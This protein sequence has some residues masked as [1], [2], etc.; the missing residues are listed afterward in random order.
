MYGRG[1]RMSVCA[2]VRAL[3]V[4]I[5]GRGIYLANPT[6]YCDSKFHHWN[7]SPQL[8]STHPL[9]WPYPNTA[10]HWHAARQIRSAS[11]TSLWSACRTN[12]V[13]LVQVILLYPKIHRLSTQSD[14]TFSHDSLLLQNPTLPHDHRH[15]NLSRTIN[16]L[17]NSLLGTK[18]SF[19]V[20]TYVTVTSLSVAERELRKLCPE[21]VSVHVLQA[22]YLTAVSILTFHLCLGPSDDLVIAQKLSIF[23]FDNSR[24]VHWD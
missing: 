7:S 9:L 18:I 12:T 22:I 11:S 5:W 23:Y 1:M 20:D 2:C 10:A 15:K 8:N 6:L 21:L 16:Y 3:N 4:Q 19:R 24:R 14:I 13:L 17:T